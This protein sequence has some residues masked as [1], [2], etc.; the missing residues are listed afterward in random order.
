LLYYKKALAIEPN[1]VATSLQI[2]KAIVDGAVWDTAAANRVPKADTATLNRMRAAFAQKIDSAKPYLKPGLTS[3]DSSQRIAA[4]VIM[5]T[6]G[7]K[8]VQQA[9]APSHAYPWLDSLL[10]IIGYQPRTAS[11]TVGPKQQIRINASFWYGISALPALS[12]PFNDVRTMK[13]SSTVKCGAAR[14][15]FERVTRTKTALQIGR[16][17]HPPTADQM[18]GYVTQYERTKPQFQAAFK[19]KPEL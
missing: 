16:R 6:A 8:L 18:L 17:I 10:S 15:L 7:S 13:G 12:K 1:D 9:Q 2:A 11:D 14:D 4:S 5:L 19:C 3:S